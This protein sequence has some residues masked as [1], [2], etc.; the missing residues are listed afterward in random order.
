MNVCSLL[1]NKYELWI[2][3]PVLAENRTVL[4]T[5]P[6]CGPCPLTASAGQWPS[7]LT[8]PSLLKS[9]IMPFLMNVHA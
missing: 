9:T 1:L 4:N 8:F 6:V 2:R 7:I 3:F 5:S